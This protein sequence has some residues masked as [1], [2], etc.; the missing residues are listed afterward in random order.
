MPTSSKIV[1]F[2]LFLVLSAAAS[3]G[4]AA[5]TQLFE[6]H[7]QSMS[8]P[9]P[10]I[11]FNNVRLFSN[12]SGNVTRWSSINTGPTTYN[13]TVLDSWL[14]DLYTHGI[15]DGV[16]YTFDQVPPWAS[17][18]NTDSA[19][20][21]ASGGNNGGC[22]LPT[23]INID[24]TGTDQDYINFITAIAQRVNNPAYLNGTAPFTQKHAHIKYWEPWNEVYR[25][26]V[27][28]TH[29]WGTYSIR[30]SYAQLVRMA[31]DLRCTIT[32]TGSILG[33]SCSATPIDSTA[34]IVSPSDGSTPALSPGSTMVFQNFLYCN[35]TGANAP[36]AGSY[37]TTGSQGSAAVDVINTHFYEAA[38]EN[39]ATDVPTYQAYLSSTD[40]AKPMWSG[41]GSWGNDTNVSTDPDMQA[42]WVARYYL[43]GWSTALVRMYW[44]AYDS[45]LYGTLWTSGSGLLA[46]GT[47][48]GTVHNWIVGSTL[49]RNCAVVAGTVWTCS[50]TLA[51]GFNAVAVWDTSQTC[52]NSSG[53]EVCTFST[54]TISNAWTKYEDLTGTDH[55][56][57]P[58]GSVNVGI[59]PIL[60]KTR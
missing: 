32:G 18:N 56:I 58:L 42:S 19:C 53:S 47:A 59:E 16:F 7:I 3:L 44:Y 60:L 45:T 22:D 30:A 41:E 14:A 29:S 25:N 28:S 48:Y 43:V 55:T 34:L 52:S 54:Q 49:T 10:T 24:G 40:L 5:N 20:D 36:I 46:P 26:S 37:C 6:L 27:V 8:T 57:S 50:L 9:W 33:T 2:L 1:L 31:E 4:Q 12:T 17:S 23:D 39:L 38:P 11:G 51:S 15:T 21:F 13:W 35:G